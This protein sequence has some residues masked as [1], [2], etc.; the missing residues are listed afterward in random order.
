MRRITDKLRIKIQ[1]L[2]HTV[3]DNNRLYSRMRSYKHIN[4]TT[5]QRQRALRAANLRGV[6]LWLKR[7]RSYCAVINR[8]DMRGMHLA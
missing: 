2:I 3:P 7:L 1:R 4:S 5:I 6:I 8:S